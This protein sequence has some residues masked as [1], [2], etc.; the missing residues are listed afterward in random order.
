MAWLAMRRDE[1]GQSTYGLEDWNSTAVEIVIG[2]NLANII[3]II[4]INIEI[5]QVG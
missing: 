5:G 1:G 2:L 4:E 3:V